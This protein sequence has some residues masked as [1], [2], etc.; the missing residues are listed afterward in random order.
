MDTFDTD[1]STSS[2]KVAIISPDN[3][4]I[5]Q[6][7][8]SIPASYDQVKAALIEAHPEALTMDELHRLIGIKQSEILMA[9]NYGLESGEMLRDATY[10]PA[11]YKVNPEM[12]DMTLEASKSVN[13]AAAAKQPAKKKRQ[14][15]LFKD[16]VTYLIKTG[17][18]LTVDEILFRT[19]IQSNIQAVR[20]ALSAQYAKKAI[21]RESW[22]TPH[23]YFVD[24]KLKEQYIEKFG[25]DVGEES[26]MVRKV[27]E[28]AAESEQNQEKSARTSRR[29]ATGPK[30]ILKK[31]RKPIVS[32]AAVTAAAEPL[33]GVTAVEP[34]KELQSE[35]ANEANAMP[36]AQTA[37]TAVPQAANF[38]A[39]IDLDGVITLV[40]DGKP[41]QLSAEQTRKL[42]RMIKF[43]AE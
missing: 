1:N 7:K 2:D 4:P 40:I 15:G 10:H 35:P 6:R 13:V 27:N 29:R 31:G 43:A 18:Y 11:R 38:N 9:T 16:I 24:G 26:G 36:Q 34:A 22:A 41:V 39:F 28:S 17:E 20:S 12:V 3:M 25:I 33:A 14:P 19:G 8:E 32:E 23:K 30:P 42:V 5:M 21:S 37:S